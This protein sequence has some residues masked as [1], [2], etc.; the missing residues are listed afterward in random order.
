MS[1]LTQGVLLYTALYMAATRTQIY[2]TAAQR[3]RLDV[4]GHRE[5][6]ALAELVRDAVD[7]YLDEHGSSDLAA[8]LDSTFGALPE[9]E[10]PSRDEWDHG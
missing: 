6:K 7:E 10:V 8:A 5:G 9:L 1:D 4:L 3:E 2:L